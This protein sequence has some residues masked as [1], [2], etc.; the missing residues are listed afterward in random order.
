MAN[1]VKSFENCISRSSISRENKLK[2][3]HLWYQIHDTGKKN[4]AESLICRTLMISRHQ[5]ILEGLN[6][7]Y[8]PILVQVIDHMM[9]FVFSLSRHT[10]TVQARIQC[11]LASAH[12]HKHQKTVQPLIGA[13]QLRNAKLAAV[14]SSA[15]AQWGEIYAQDGSEAL[16]GLRRAHSF[17]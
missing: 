17:I 15:V 2:V 14:G 16:K 10:L 5:E 9:P 12:E 8:I 4:V 3:G 1:N 13:T 11:D 6:A 7:Q